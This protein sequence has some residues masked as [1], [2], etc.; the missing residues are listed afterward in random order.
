MLGLVNV[1]LIVPPELEL[2]P[3]IAPVIPPIVQLYVLATLE[4]K[5]IPVELP[6]QIL[7]VEAFVIAGVGFTLTVIVYVLP[8][9]K[10]PV[11][12]GVIKYS[13]VPTTELLGFVN[14]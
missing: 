5:V 10:P 13:T 8:V 11:E 6:L 4:V 7:F 3:V 9:H 12:T 14:T 1:W 2:E